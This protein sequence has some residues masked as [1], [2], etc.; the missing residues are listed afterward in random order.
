MPE[1]KFEGTIPALITPFTPEG[2]VDYEGLRANIKF[3][4]ENGVSG[5]VPLG[6][7]GETP[8][9]HEDE[10]EKIVNIC[11]EEVK[12]KVPIIVGAGTNSTEKT[13][14]ASKKA[15]EWGADALLIVNPYYNKPTQ[16]GLYLHFR[17]VAES[18]DVP[19]VV[20]NIKGRTG[21]N[22]ET[23]TMVELAKI[24]NITAVKEASGDLNQMK[25]V[26]A[27]TDL[28]VLSGDDGITLPLMKEGGKGII[29]VA[30]NLVPDRMS[31]LTNAALAENWEEAEKIDEELKPLYDVEFIETNPI[32]IK[33]AMNMKGMAAG[34][35]R[36]PLCELMPENEAKLKQVLQEMGIL[37]K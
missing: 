37:E 25:D 23:P 10:K 32:P 2:K 31:A 11:V 12:G 7:T 33:A 9:L 15:V 24:E 36:L 21:V 1:I 8:T 3:Q 17:A 6:T 35:Y 27:Q 5:L 16:R 30:A 29:S 22:I 28:T 19:I 20:Y 14:E 26:L 18:V 13:I 4:L 34:G